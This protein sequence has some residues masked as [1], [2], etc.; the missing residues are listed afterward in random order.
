M[1]DRI[2]LRFFMKG[3]KFEII[4]KMQLF[5]FKAYLY[6]LVLDQI[7]RSAADYQV[8][9]ERIE[10]EKRQMDAAVSEKNNIV[11]ERQRVEVARLEKE[12][13]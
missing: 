10:T 7:Q 1:S 9:V 11:I 12:K 8:Q 2:E 5:T 4:N 3:A 13:V 6:F